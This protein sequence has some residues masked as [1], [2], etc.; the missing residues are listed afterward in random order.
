MSIFFYSFMLVAIGSGKKY[1]QQGVIHAAHS[2]Y[3]LDRFHTGYAFK[4]L[5]AI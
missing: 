1:G 4:H 5:L 3:R 2:L